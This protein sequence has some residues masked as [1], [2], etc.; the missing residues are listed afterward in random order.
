MRNKFHIWPEVA[1]HLTLGGITSDLKW[2]H[3]WPW[4]WYVYRCISNLF[5]FS[6]QLH[7][8]RR[9]WPAY[10][11]LYLDW[12]RPLHRLML[13]GQLKLP[14]GETLTFNVIKYTRA[15]IIIQPVPRYDTTLVYACNCL[16]LRHH[17]SNL[18]WYIPY[19]WVVTSLGYHLPCFSRSAPGTQ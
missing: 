16:P 5:S 3:I 13:S 8:V 7:N 6:L 10:L 18:C 19:K 15:K 4:F 17:Y 14:T 11:F 2:R 1:S 12:L 9:A